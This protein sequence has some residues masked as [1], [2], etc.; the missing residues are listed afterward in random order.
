MSRFLEKLKAKN[1]DLHAEP[2]R[3]AFLGDSVT[4][5]CFE[6]YRN[7]PESVETV[8]D[9][10]NAYSAC[11]RKIFAAVC[12]RVPVAII[13]TGI[14]GDNAP[15]GLQRLERDVLACRPDLVVV[16]FGLN[17]SG[18]GLDG[19]QRYSD[20]VRG[21]LRRLRAGGI[22]AILMTPNMMCSHVDC[23]ITDELER[24][25]AAGIVPVQT[26]GVLDA[27]VQAARAAAAAE[28]ARLCDCYALWKAM[29]T[30]GLDTTAMLSNHINHPTRELHWLF[31]WKLFQTIFEE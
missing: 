27:Y 13:N 31:A 3:I 28:D 10:E 22:D 25:I 5:G 24:R 18:A 16:C 14:S 29:D 23:R 21:I 7:G 4:Q 12:P 9:P 17:D 26:D 2:V 11:L 8:F 1:A 15:N 6:I 19:L 30:A 20:A